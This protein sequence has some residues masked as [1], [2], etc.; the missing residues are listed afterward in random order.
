MKHLR[1]LRIGPGG[2]K[3]VCCFPAPGSKDRKLAYRAAK[4][5]D[6]REAFKAEAVEQAWKPEHMEDEQA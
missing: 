2:R 1:H 6:K 3:C 5:K 4:R